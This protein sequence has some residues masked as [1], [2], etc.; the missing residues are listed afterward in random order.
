MN[1]L[2]NAQFMNGI[3]KGEQ[4]AYRNGGHALC[5]QVT[6]YLAGLLFVQGSLYRAV[7]T[8]ALGDG[9]IETRGNQRI[10]LLRLK[11]VERGTALCADLHQIFEA[12]RGDESQTAAF[13]FN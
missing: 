4:S 5:L 13:L 9:T 3:D 2:L 8:D 6:Y 11:V 12:L 10:G 7:I 1:D